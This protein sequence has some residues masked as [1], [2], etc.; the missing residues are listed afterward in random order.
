MGGKCP[1]GLFVGLLSSDESVQSRSVCRTEKRV[2]FIVGWA[3][4]SRADEIISKKNCRLNSGNCSE[5][6]KFGSGKG[7]AS[8]SG[9]FEPVKELNFTKCLHLNV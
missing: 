4:A 3:G 9:S 2:F 5:I 6:C 1:F 8:K 7:F